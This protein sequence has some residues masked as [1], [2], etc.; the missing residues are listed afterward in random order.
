MRKNVTI[1]LSPVEFIPLAEET[2][3]IDALGQWVLRTACQTMAEWHRQYSEFD[4]IS[5]AVNVSGRQFLTP[6]SLSTIGAIL[7]ETGTDPARVRLE[8]TENSIID[9]AP[10]SLP[11]LEE[12]RS[13]NLR[14]H[15]DDFGTGYSSLSFMKKLPIDALKIDRSFV[16]TMKTDP[17][18]ES[19][20]RATIALAHNLEFS[21]TAEGVETAEQA[22]RLRQLN[23]DSAQGYYFAHPMTSEATLERL[24]HSRSESATA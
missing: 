1:G 7:E 16:E 5:I 9:N 8:I 15:I 14:L 3:L 21:V 20:V 11:V 13:H 4:Q 2:G 12:L 6:A 22:Q 10:H 19:I 23:C 24:L 18:S 17:I